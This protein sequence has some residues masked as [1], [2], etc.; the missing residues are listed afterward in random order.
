MM[1][2]SNTNKDSS[3]EKKAAAFSLDFSSSD[4]FYTTLLDQVFSELRKRRGV[5]LSRMDDERQQQIITLHA[6]GKTLDEIG[7][8]F[9]VTRERIRQIERK[10]WA[11]IALFKPQL[12]GLESILIGI[13]RKNG[14][15]DRLS[16]L[17]ERLRERFGWTVKE[18]DYLL[19]HYL[20]VL[21]DRFEIIL[22]DYIALSDYRCWRCDHFLQQ[23]SSVVADIEKDNGSVTIGE[24]SKKVLAVLDA[25]PEC[26]QC[27]TKRFGLSQELFL[28][29][30]KNDPALL[31]SQEKMTVR[32]TSQFPGLNRSVLLVLKIARMPLS[33]K[34][35]LSELKK[36]FPK[37]R[38]T[39]K[40][41]QSTTSNSPQCFDEIFLWGRG[42]IH[43]ETLYIHK[44]Y[45]KTDLPVL[46][47]IE[48]SLLAELGRGK[49]PQIRLNRVFN[50][51][52]EQCVKAGIPNVYALFSSLKVRAHEGL[53]FLRSP[54]IGF[55]GSRQKISNA[56]ILEDFVRESDHPVTRQEM[57][58]FGRSLGLQDEHI[59]NTIVLTELLATQNGYV[60]RPDFPAD[61][62][63]FT[64]LLAQMEKGLAKKSSLVIGDFF[65]AEYGLCQ[66][67][68]ILDAK[69]LYSLLRRFADNSFELKYP[70][71]QLKSKKRR[72]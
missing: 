48:K 55:A 19:D 62:P 68:D 13:L 22:E 39:L 12:R 72:K 31:K 56:K 3:A 20:G 34:E 32:R 8:M 29:L 64:E 65:R 69:M 9:S 71:I 23:V 63:L 5:R 47:E 67:L 4:R 16:R 33:K 70:L 36:M 50:D 18:I 46:D 28:W 27:K 10:V 21:T 15:F 7:K 2:L 30:F 11:Q 26:A 43:S 42:G 25:S 59:S 52:S 17:K 14:S 41:I 44:D 60:I 35:I 1:Y 57:R 45:I 61:G 51:Y 53:C 37:R 40:Q 66:K 24:F 54:Y 6:S 49:V 58:K 38:F